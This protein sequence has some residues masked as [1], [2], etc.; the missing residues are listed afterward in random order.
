MELSKYQKAAILINSLSTDISAMI[1]ATFSPKE[2]EEIM[3][4]SQTLSNIP[5]SVKDEVLEEFLNQTQSIQSDPIDDSFNFS[6]DDISGGGDFSLMGDSSDSSRPLGFL[7]RLDSDKLLSLIRKEHPQTIA[8]IISFLQES[9]AS[10]V[11]TQLPPHLQTEVARRLAELGKIPADV[12]EEVQVILQNKLSRLLE[13]GGGY[14]QTAGEG[15]EMLVNILSQSDSNVE[16]KIMSGLSQKNPD[17][18]S[19]LRGKLCEFEDIA[20]LDDSSIK[21]LLKM[22]ND[23]DLVLALKGAPEYI[24]NKIL[25]C[26]PPQQATVIR[27]EIN[28]IDV[29]GAEEIRAAKLSIRNI[30]R[31][32]VSMAKIKF[33]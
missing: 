3:K 11:I 4:I 19:E 31:T 28:E 21:H 26:L 16:E 29:I 1:M 23:K 32:Q 20:R 15:K 2:K 14:R 10:E 12:L 33:Y 6:Y 18:A 13:Y 27:R 8:L 9:Q 7:R 30:M 17:L 24:V 22:I 5:A 25:N